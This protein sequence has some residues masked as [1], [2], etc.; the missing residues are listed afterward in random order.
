MRPP[1]D[2]PAPRIFTRQALAIDA[3]I[4]LEPGPGRHL[5]GALRRKPGDPVILFDGSGGEYQAIITDVDRGTVQAQVQGFQ[6][7]D[8][9]ASLPVFLG[10]AVSRGERMDYAVQK[11]TE[12][13][14]SELFPLLTERTEVRLKPDRLEKKQRHWQE[15][16]N[17]ACEQCGRNRPPQ[18]HMAQPLS[19]WLSTAPGHCKLV[20]HH[21]SKASLADLEPPESACLLVGPEGGLSAEEIA[22]AEAAGFESLALGPRVLRTETAPVAA[23]AVLQY[24]WGDLQ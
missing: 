4:R 16:A 7:I 18:V 24:Q 19:A 9:E 20:L 2:L 10:L 23:L 14:V 15:I 11:S 1:P 22:A 21:R 3:V 8:R 17:S 5:A 12:L 6:S 13:G